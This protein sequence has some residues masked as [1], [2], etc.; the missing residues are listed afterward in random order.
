MLGSWRLGYGFFRWDFF[1]YAGMGVN[2]NVRGWEEKWV[3]K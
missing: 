2:V 1:L 3:N